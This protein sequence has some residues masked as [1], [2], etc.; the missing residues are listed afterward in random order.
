MRS[1]SPCR[2]PGLRCVVAVLTGRGVASLAVCVV[3]Q[4]FLSAVHNRHTHVLNT[5]RGVLVHGIGIDAKCPAAVEDAAF[6]ACLAAEAHAVAAAVA[7]TAAT[8]VLFTAPARLVRAAAVAA[9]AARVAGHLQQP[10]AVTVV[11]PPAVH[12]GGDAAGL[13]PLWVLLRV[14]AHARGGSLGGAV[15]N[16]GTVQLTRSTRQRAKPCNP[17]TEPGFWTVND[18][19]ARPVTGADDDDPYYDIPMRLQHRVEW[20]AVRDSTV[21]PRARYTDAVRHLQVGG[22]SEASFPDVAWLQHRVV[23][24]V[25]ALRGRWGL[26]A[27]CFFLFV[28]TT[29]R[30]RRRLGTRLSA[31][32]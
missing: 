5:T 3:A 32:S 30:T 22:V 24:L 20:R 26:C 11:H 21:C 18:E 13:Q 9:V 2:T 14:H 15:G 23:V 16:D 31:T 6:A 17:G 10:S 29:P 1:C 25:R 12:D 19:P 4:A 28:L 27:A 8:L 7:P